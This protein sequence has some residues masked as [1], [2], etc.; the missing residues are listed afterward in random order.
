[1]LCFIPHIANP[2]GIGILHIENRY[3]IGILH[4]DDRYICIIVSKNLMNY[5]NIN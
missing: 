3:G 2:Y 5:D 1:M 4:I